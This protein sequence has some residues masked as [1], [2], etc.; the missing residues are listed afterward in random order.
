MPAG[1]PRFTAINQR[2]ELEREDARRIVE[3]LVS[4]PRS[5]ARLGLPTFRLLVPNT[6][7]HEGHN[8]KPDS[9]F[10]GEITEWWQTLMVA[11]LNGNS[12]VIVGTGCCRFTP[13]NPP[14]RRELKYQDA[15][16]IVQHV[17]FKCLPHW[18][19]KT[20]E[21]AIPNSLIHKGSNYIRESWSTVEI[22]MWWQ[23]L[24]VGLL[25]ERMAAN[26][27]PPMCIKDY[28]YLNG[29]DLGS[30]RGVSAGCSGLNPPL[31]GQ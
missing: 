4:G 8:D 19:Q 6:P 10:T 13:I 7:I 27:E 15:F 24:M 2:R 25:N 1:H 12:N 29:V 14:Q 31:P 20:F 23:S 18:E 26:S 30:E 16:R 28:S 21:L 5:L 22:T 9:W 11:L 17:A 3:Y